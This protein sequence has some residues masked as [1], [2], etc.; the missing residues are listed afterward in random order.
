MSSCVMQAYPGVRTALECREKVIQISFM[1]VCKS[2]P[3]F[4]SVVNI[5]QMLNIV[6]S[7]IGI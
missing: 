7:T 1:K 2:K 3:Y 5:I 4:Q 6:S